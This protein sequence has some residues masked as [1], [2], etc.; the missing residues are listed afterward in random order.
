MYTDDFDPALAE[1]DRDRQGQAMDGALSGCLIFPVTPGFS[2][3]TFWFLPPN[4]EGQGTR[5]VLEAWSQH[6]SPAPTRGTKCCA[7]GQN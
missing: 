4:A 5:W 3:P 7:L 6:R 2:M 1:R